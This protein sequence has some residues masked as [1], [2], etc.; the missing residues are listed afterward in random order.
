MLRDSKDE[1]LRFEMADR[2]ES[3]VFKRTEME[4]ATEEILSNEGIRYQ[5]SDSLN[6]VLDKKD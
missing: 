6:D 5:S 2:S 1:F 3:L 4:A